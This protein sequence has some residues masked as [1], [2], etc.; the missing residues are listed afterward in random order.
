VGG[1]GGA[2]VAEVFVVALEEVDAAGVE[3]RGVGRAIDHWG[4]TEERREQ[5]EWSV[6]NG[7]WSAGVDL[8]AVRRLTIGH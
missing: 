3:I 5:R 6:V 2:A 8:V 1:V 4:N 7:Q